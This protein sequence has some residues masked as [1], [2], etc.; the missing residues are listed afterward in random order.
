VEVKNAEKETDSASGS[1]GDG[2]GKA[3]DRAGSGRGQGRGSVRRAVSSA[4]VFRET[5]ARE[6]VT[7]P[8]LKCAS[9]NLY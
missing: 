5:C 3:R 9:W 7:D 8:S 4:R 1:P 2:P 6:A